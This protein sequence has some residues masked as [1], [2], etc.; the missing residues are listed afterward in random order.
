MAKHTREI[1]EN[2][3]ALE[4]NERSTA[5]NKWA[6]RNWKRAQKAGPKPE[7]TWDEMVATWGKDLKAKLRPKTASTD[8][9][10]QRAMRSW[11]V[12][13]RDMPGP[14]RRNNQDA[15]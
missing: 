10:W 15:T 9:D 12:T 13:C 11:R 6:L 7:P 2:P 8:P 3:R 4:T 1:G 14:E 5:R